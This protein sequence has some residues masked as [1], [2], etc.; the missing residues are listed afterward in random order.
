MLDIKILT[1][2]RSTIP[3]LAV[4]TEDFTEY[5]KNFGEPYCFEQVAGKFRLAVDGLTIS[6]GSVPADII[7]YPEDDG[8][9]N[10]SLDGRLVYR[11][12]CNPGQMCFPA[13]LF[14]SRLN[15]TMPPME[16]AERPIV[17]FCGVTRRPVVRA[18]TI[19]LFACM[20]N[21]DFRLISRKGFCDA[22]VAGYNESIRKSQYVLCPQGVGR[23]SYRLYETLASGRI[24]ILDGND[25]LPEYP[26]YYVDGFRRES[27]FDFHKNTDLIVAGEAN[28]RFWVEKCSP[29][30]WMSTQMEK[31]NSL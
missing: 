8:H 3:F 15:L 26:P 24:P 13:W 16:E 9:F 18:T 28:R 31:F 20:E 11:R 27:L 4:V 7:M 5:R 30:G 2:C 21:I 23:F 6:N 1:V 14:P 22:D 19:K 25:I 12:S 29:F 17:S 10:N